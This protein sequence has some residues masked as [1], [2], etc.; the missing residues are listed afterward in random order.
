M[1]DRDDQAAMID[2]PDPFLHVYALIFPTA[3]VG[4]QF[5]VE[6]GYDRSKP[7]LFLDTLVGAKILI[8]VN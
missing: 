4:T 7:F 1:L 3:R 5:V 6:L 8:F 2:N